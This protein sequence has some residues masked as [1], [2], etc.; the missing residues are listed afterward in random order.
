VLLSPDKP[1][2]RHLA[3]SAETSD[4]SDEIAKADCCSS[5]TAADVVVGV[6]WLD[7]TKLGLSEETADEGTTVSKAVC[8]FTAGEGCARMAAEATAAAADSKPAA[9]EWGDSEFTSTV[10]LIGEDI[11][12]NQSHSKCECMRGSAMH[13]V[14]TCTVNGCKGAELRG[15]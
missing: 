10:V 15:G 8:G 1:V 4:D 7:S 5:V 6:T 13:G 11:L 14:C 12:H 9:A 3:E 2:F